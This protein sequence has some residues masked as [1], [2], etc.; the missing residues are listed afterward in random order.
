MIMVMIVF[1][2][3]GWEACPLIQLHTYNK[4]NEQKI[5]YAYNNYV[6]A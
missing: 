6:M 2:G 4:Y 5:N 1:Q 3:W